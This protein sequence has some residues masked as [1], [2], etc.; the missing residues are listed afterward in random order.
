MKRRQLPEGKGQ[1]DEGTKV[2]SQDRV[3]KKVIEDDVGIRGWVSLGGEFVDI[4][5][6]S[7]RRRNPDTL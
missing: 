4:R 3:G 6:C 1:V 7:S 5:K 2:S